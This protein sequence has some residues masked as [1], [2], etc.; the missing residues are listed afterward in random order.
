[1]PKKEEPEE[2]LDDGA[3]PEMALL[4]VQTEALMHE[5]EIRKRLV[6]EGFA[7]KQQ[8]L[9]QLSEEKA[10]KYN[11]LRY[12]IQA[13]VNADAMADYEDTLREAE[14]TGGDA[15]APPELNEEGLEPTE[16]EQDEIDRRVKALSGGPMLILGVRRVDAVE[17][18]NELM[19]I[20]QE[21]GTKNPALKSN[22]TE[23]GEEEEAGGDDDEGPS[24]RA[25]YGKTPLLCAVRG[26][27][28]DS[29]STGPSSDRLRER[30]R[31]F[32]FGN[33][34]ATG[35][36][37][38]GGKKGKTRRLISAKVSMEQLQKF[39]FPPRVQ[40]PL[41][42][43]RL[44]IFALYGP[45]DRDS[46]LRAGHMGKHIVT[47]RELDTMSATLAREDILSVYAG[48]GLA[49]EEEEEILAQADGAMKFIPQ[50]TTEDIERILKL[51]PRDEDGLMSFHD[52]QMAISKARA[53]HVRRLKD[54]MLALTKSKNK[55]AQTAPVEEKDRLAEQVKK[56]GKKPAAKVSRLVA[57][58]TMFEADM[59]VSETENAVVISKMLAKHSFKICQV[60]T[61]NNP[62]LTQ[63]VRLLKDD[64][65]Y[66]EGQE[67]WDNNCCLKGKQRGTFVK[68][69]NAPGHK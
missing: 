34:E 36:E 17:K 52:M 12:R 43:G 10:I 7:I 31:D 30:E 28:A 62:Q 69:K 29:D 60:E 20:E 44:F 46:L 33:E 19:G 14:E 3:E 1:M 37:D 47:A 15:G 61:G 41:S 39:L 40:H 59:G 51:V 45:L 67:V 11:M 49:P 8:T 2:E 25:L 5:E 53:K 4:I 55:Q 68:S 64:Y 35:L 13:E 21:S 6:Q 63:N 57:P 50:Y 23:E 26:S 56:A 38:N 48:Q 24:L 32:F 9:A 16:E 58:P 27:N 66:K 18:L 65:R 54:A 42:T 22:N